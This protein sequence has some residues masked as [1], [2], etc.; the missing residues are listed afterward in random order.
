[1]LHIAIAAEFEL[2]EKIAE[3]LEKSELEIER[4][5]VAEI[6]PF[7]EEQGIRFRN[8]AVAQYAADEMNWSDVQYLLFAG[9]INQV[10]IAAK[11]SEAGTVVVDMR[12]ICA[13]LSD[14][15]VVIPGINEQQLTELRQRN[16]VALP[17][18]QVT[19][20]ALALA[21]LLQE[22]PLKHATV[23]SLLPAAYNNEEAVGKLAGQT[24]R[25]LNGI[26]LE[27]EEQR[28]AF[29]VFPLQTANLSSQL[30]KI[31]P[32]AE[33]FIFHSIQ[34]PVFY[35]TGQKITALSDYAIDADKLIALW[36]QNQWIRY[37][38]EKLPTPVTNGEM[39]NETDE[40]FLH[41]G[42][43]A[44]TE[45]AVSFWTVAD[46]QRFSLALMAVKLTEA[47]Y[48]AGY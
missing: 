5:S 6:Y 38:P 47:I 22:V 2:S 37:Q 39:E 41:V 45:S 40:A 30:G 44:T 7:N 24:A 12:G 26:P 21:P 33:D 17:D 29:D 8:K 9:D 27:D 10:S 13:S 14:V 11:A 35:G 42:N 4:L 25:L 32:Q 15:P 36:Q 20:A 48:R 3:T 34:V 16:I 23:T 46:E 19:Q 31:F 1:M 43:L 28:L 18:S